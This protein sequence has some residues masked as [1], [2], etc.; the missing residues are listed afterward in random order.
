MLTP[1]CGRAGRFACRF[2]RGAQRAGGEEPMKRTQ[3]LKAQY[4]LQM[5]EEG[6]LLAAATI[7]EQRLQRQGRIHSPDQAGSYLVARCAHLP[8]EVFGVVFLDTKH[9]ILAAEH[10]FTGTIDGCE[11]HPRVV[12]KRA[13]GLNAVALILFHNHPSGNPEP[14]EADCKVTQRLQEALGLLDIRI[15]DHLVI[16]GQK[17][18]SLA[19][20]GWA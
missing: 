10:L 17:S 13:L 19:S 5:D 14:S 8:H 18:V 4:Q 9:H 2:P 3:D 1:G 20:R 7:L 12:A 16:G 6:I 15:L 11:V